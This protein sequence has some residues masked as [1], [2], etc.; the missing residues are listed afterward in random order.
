MVH[1]IPKRWTIVF[2]ALNTLL[3][4]HQL[5]LIPYSLKH[6]LQ[7]QQ[8]LDHRSMDVLGT[9]STANLF[10][11]SRAL[12]PPRPSHKQKG[13][14]GACVLSKDDNGNLQEWLPYHYTLLPL[15][16]LLVGVDEDSVEDPNDVL[17]RWNKADLGL[18]IKLANASEFVNLFSEF[19]PKKQRREKQ[20][21]QTEI[22]L[23]VEAHQLL[24]HK[25]QAFIAYCTRHMKQL[26][27]QWVSMWD[28]DEFLVV[29]R[30]GQDERDSKSPSQERDTKMY[31]LQ[32]SLLPNMEST[33]TVMDIIHNFEQSNTSLDA[34]HV[35]PRVSFGALE[36]YSCPNV[37]S[38]IAQIHAKGFPTDH[39]NTLRFHQHARKDDFQANKWGKVMLNLEA[40]PNQTLFQSIPSNIHRPYK[41]ECP[42]PAVNIFQAPFALM[43]H[44]GSWEQYQNRDDARRSYN[45]WATRAFL[46][47]SS[48]FCYQE[49][50]R[51]LPRFIEEV[52]LEQARY[53][54]GA[55]S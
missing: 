41:K 10:L 37:S 28:T 26:G 8:D 1:S 29:N 51:W 42:R 11:S 31:G 40:I 6:V 18:N 21:N 49:V 44:L 55:D 17:R 12:S 22:K 5:R 38:T 16:Y 50:H 35:T 45:A 7:L 39:L 19:A 15:R 33:A 54:L 9:S 20:Q 2:L 52:G 14:F 53:L 27:V 46:D 48:S 4:F 32:R 24:K 36:K 43:H 3:F 23:A 34:C 30:I 25:Q 13:G 47:A